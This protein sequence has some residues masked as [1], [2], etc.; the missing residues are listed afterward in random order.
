LV[1]VRSDQCEQIQDDN[2]ATVTKNRRS[3]Y[4]AHTRELWS[5]TLNDNFTAALYGIDMNCDRMIA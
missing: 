1:L 2:N 4:T 5:Q 3:R